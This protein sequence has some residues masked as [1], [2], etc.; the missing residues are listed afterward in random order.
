MSNPD[1]VLPPTKAPCHED[2]RFAVKLKSTQALYEIPVGRSVL[3]VLEENGVGLPFACAEGIC[4]TCVTGV[5]AGTP[6]HYDM[7]LE[8][9]EQAENDQFT[10]CCSRSK[11]AMLI[12][13]L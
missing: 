7:F 6:D 13:D 5:I 9:D 12:L 10:P 2:G 1:N 11:T 4:G 3:E 8:E